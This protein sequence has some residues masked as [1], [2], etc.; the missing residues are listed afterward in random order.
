MAAKSSLN[1]NY[2]NIWR[3]SFTFSNIIGHSKAI[4]NAI[5]LAKIAANSSA[6]VLI[7]GESGVGK[8][9][10]A[11]AIHNHSKRADQPFVSINCGAI[12]RELIE[13][14]LFGYVPNAFTGASPHGALGKFTIANKGTLFLDEVAELSSDAQVKL[15]R[16]ISLGE[17]VKIGGTTPEKIDVRIICATNKNLLNEVKNGNFREDLYYRLNVFE[18]NVPPLRERLDD[19]NEIV[20]YFV[21]KISQKVFEANFENEIQISPKFI[22]NLKKY[23]W[24][25]NVRQL[26]AVL[27]REIYHLSGPPYVLSHLPDYII[28]STSNNENIN[29][30]KPLWQVELETIKY[31]LEQYNWNI[32]K[33]TNILQISRSTLYRKI[34]K[35]KLNRRQN[36]I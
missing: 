15:L 33:V 12:P 14:E 2:A 3:A 34:Q 32:D 31:A 20:N 4:S 6:S 7:T 23:H 8:E 11:H 29:L 26:Q 21:K 1:A 13:A 5:R 24:P 30:V 22:E 35:Y 19:I 36:K 25:G 28:N 27:E 10:F 18:I 17:I 16:A 9:M